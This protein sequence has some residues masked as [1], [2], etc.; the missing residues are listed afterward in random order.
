MTRQLRNEQLN[1]L[2][3][4]TKD[5]TES[6]RQFNRVNGQWVSIQEFNNDIQAT[7]DSL[8]SSGGTIFVPDGDYT[9]SSTLT[10][11]KPI[12]MMLG[13][14]TLTL[15]VGGIVANVNLTI[16]GHGE[17]QSIISCHS[18]G[19]G[20]VVPVGFNGYPSGFTE[21]AAAIFLARFTFRTIPNLSISNSMGLLVMLTLM[22]YVA[23]YLMELLDIV[24][25][26]VLNSLLNVSLA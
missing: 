16:I 22:S 6:L 13:R 18:G 5:G 24:N 1:A 15:A 11:T 4:S 10:F 19:K 9:V 21:G 23:L 3:T 12:R 17:S 7:H 25:S 26:I 8:P 2:A 14:G 20:I